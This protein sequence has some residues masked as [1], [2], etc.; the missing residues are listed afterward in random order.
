[1]QLVISL[2]DIPSCQSG[3]TVDVRIDPNNREDVVV[4]F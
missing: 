2:M 3:E 1:M 4:L